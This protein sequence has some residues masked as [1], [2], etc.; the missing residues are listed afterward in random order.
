M[1]NTWN[2]WNVWEY[3]EG[4]PVLQCERQNRFVSI[5]GY[6]CSEQKDSYTKSKAE[7]KL[8]GTRLTSL[9]ETWGRKLNLQVK[10][11]LIVSQ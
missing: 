8:W 11:F 7:W 6:S 4:P 3:T 10:Y 1:W 2:I 5:I 9:K